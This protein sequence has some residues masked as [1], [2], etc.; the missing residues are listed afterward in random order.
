MEAKTFIV[1]PYSIV[2]IHDVWIPHLYLSSSLLSSPPVFP[3][4]L[5]S[6]QW[7]WGSPLSCFH[8]S[9]NH[10]PS[11]A[12]IILG[13]EV[14]A[15]YGVQ[16]VSQTVF[17]DFAKI[18]FLFPVGQQCAQVNL[19]PRFLSS[20]SSPFPFRETERLS[21]PYRTLLENYE[22]SNSRE[23]RGGIR[24]KGECERRAEWTG[25]EEIQKGD[26][27]DEWQE[28]VRW[29]DWTRNKIN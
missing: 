14:A 15:Q 19:L 10:H 24:V 23:I 6:T 26:N 21:K 28:K 29:Q 4:P 9:G 11:K 25:G 27:R 7:L 12:L 22:K 13:K 18:A 2:D 1:P 20:Q 8:T 3:H 17:T 16:W 5:C